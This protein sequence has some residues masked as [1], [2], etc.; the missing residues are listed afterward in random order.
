MDARRAAVRSAVV[1]RDDM[2]ASMLP[3]VPFAAGDTFRIVEIG[4]GESALTAALRDRFPLATLVNTG[5]VAVD[6]LAWW[7]LMFGAGLVV[8]VLQLHQLNDAKKQYLFKAAAD[9]L[10]EQGALL[11]ADELPPFTLLHHLVWLKHAGFSNVDCF[12]R[13]GTRAVLGGVRPAGA[14]AL[15]LR[16]DN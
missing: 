10:S 11:I 13:S 2:I 12:W 14:S 9:R 3:L 8:S 4:P 7:D 15:P 16:A 1:M 5:T 6:S